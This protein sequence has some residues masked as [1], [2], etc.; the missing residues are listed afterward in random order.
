MA[1]GDENAFIQ[2]ALALATDNSGRPAVAVSAR[3]A[4]LALGWDVVV[5]RLEAVMLEA[6]QCGSLS[7]KR[8]LQLAERGNPA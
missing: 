7:G 8:P 1:P 2:A 5:Q 4:M 3:Q 6:V